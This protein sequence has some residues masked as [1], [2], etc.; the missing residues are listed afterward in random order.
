MSQSSLQSRT[1]GHP[2]AM[3]RFQS[4]LGYAAR[5]A[6][7]ALLGLMFLSGQALAC[8]CGCSTFDVGFSGL[9]QEDD[10]GGRVF[11]E[12]D[13]QNQNKNWIGTSKASPDLSADKQIKTNFYNVG[14]EYMFNRSWGVMAKLPYAMRSFKTD[15][16]FGAGPPSISTYNSNAIGDVEI[17]AMYTGFST[18][19][20]TGLTFG[21][22]LPTG[23]Y[24]AAGFD[25]DTQIGSGSTDLVLGGFHRGLITA[26]NSWQYF[27]QL[28]LQ[29]PFA[30]ND[31]K[32][33]DGN[34]ITYRPGRQLDGAVGI[35]YNNGYNVL[36]FDKVAPVL[37]LI[38]TYRQSD[39]GTGASPTNT[40]FTRLMIA[41]G[42]EFTKVI[43]EANKKVFKIY[44]DVEIPIYQDSHAVPDPDNGTQGQLVAPMLF[45]LV[46]SINF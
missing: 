42:I 19:M 7:F 20:S 27:T 26:D 39:W 9:P 37:Q 28:R 41:P 40:G 43:D 23:E 14:F 24:N 22:K 31:S 6:G 4:S 33:D 13:F 11:F 34:T 16:N 12:W 44:G 46:S 3:R 2:Y 5:R 17:S 18:D 21:L 45:K 38:G 1:A 32:D 15:D 35:V 8:A 29:Q 36:G 10:H 30:Y 25:R